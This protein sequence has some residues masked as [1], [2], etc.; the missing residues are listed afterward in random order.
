MEFRA[1]S[2]LAAAIT[3]TVLAA[4]G[5]PPGSGGSLRPATG[6]GT[7]LATPG[8]IASPEPGPPTFETGQAIELFR[9]PTNVAVADLDGDGTRDL[10][11]CS[12]SEPLIAVLFGNGDGTFG[13][14]PFVHA[15]QPCTFV[16]AA[17]LDG[18]G[19][20][21]L[22]TSSRDGN[23]TVLL[24]HRDGTFDKPVSYAVK[25][26]LKNGGVSWLTTAD[27]NGDGQPDLVAAVHAVGQPD[28]AAPGHLG[29]LINKGRGTFADAALYPDRAAAAVVARDFDGDAELDVVS[30]DLDGTV[31]FF[32]GSGT[33]RL[34]AA[35]ES[36]GGDGVAIRAGDVNGD[37]VLDLA[38]GNGASSS[39]SVLP[40]VGDGTFGGA[41]QFPA[42]DTR[43]IAMV[44]LDGDGHLDLLA[45]GSDETFVRLWRGRGDGTF[46]EPGRIDTAG[47]TVRDLAAADLN[48]DGRPDLVVAD[49]HSS[50][51]VF[52]GN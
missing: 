35:M 29:V 44:D 7:P 36:N 48:G 20:V 22:A 43:T 34:G 31:R 52:L 2:L 51:H 17:D 16:L 41:A 8:R 50:L 45:G 12:E 46:L 38:T 30:A 19:T 40:G 23:A 9:D 21:D 26:K 6:T 27:L 5:G 3:C 49:A 14:A 4:C 25:D 42:G 32:R 18:D 33:G 13:T 28:A 24:G 11:T 39:V 10:A 37:G 47:A 15:G 1:R